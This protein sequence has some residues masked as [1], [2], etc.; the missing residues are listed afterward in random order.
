MGDEKIKDLEAREKAV[1][2]KEEELVAKEKFLAD[3][4]EFLDKREKELADQEKALAGKGPS[5]APAEAEEKPLTKD[6]QKL[7]D[8][9][10]KAYGIDKEYLLKSRIDPHTKEAILVTHGGAKVRF[11]KGI[12]VEILDP[13][14]VDGKP[15]KKP[16]VVAG[17]KK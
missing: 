5:I 14:R 15:R 4:Q 7:I 12:E 8:D 17:K 6:E 13:V 2:E 11:K 3:L 1:A 9:G 16:R 10:C